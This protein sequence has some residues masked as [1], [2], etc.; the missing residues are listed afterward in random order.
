MLK[1]EVGGKV[2]VLGSRGVGKSSICRTLLNYSVKIGWQTC[3]VDLDIDNNDIACC[4]AIAAGC[5]SEYI[6]YDCNDINKLAYFFPYEY[7]NSGNIEVYANL[8]RNLMEAVDKRMIKDKEDFVR[9]NTILGRNLVASGQKSIYASNSII[10]TPA[11][12]MDMSREQIKQFISIVNPY[13]VLVVDNDN[14]ISTLKEFKDLLVLKIPKNGGVV[15][16]SEENQKK[17][18]LLKLE[19][20]FFD[21]RFIC[22]RD[23]IPLSKLT[24]YK[25][26]H[27]GEGMGGNKLDYML[28]KVDP[29][30]DDLNKAIIG[31]LQLENRGLTNIPDQNKMEYVLK[32]PLLSIIFIFEIKEGG[33]GGKEVVVIRPEYLKNIYI[34]NIWIL[35]NQKYYRN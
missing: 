10:N 2:L 21:E 15:Q 16:Y 1:N 27:A 8:V 20:Y 24:I 6:P 7:L 31:V 23:I 35:S 11:Y 22:S 29:S 32:K 18:R 28:V 34:D 3:Y 17:N 4:S 26:V 14:I 9:S 12:I 25:Y 33:E 19:R 30:V 13:L 5:F